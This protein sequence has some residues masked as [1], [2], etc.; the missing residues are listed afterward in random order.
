[1]KIS[2]IQNTHVLGTETRLSF[3]LIDEFRKKGIDVIVN[4]CDDE[5]DVILCMNGLSQFPTVK[6]ISNKYPNKKV[7]IYVWDVY[8]W[9][10]YASGYDDIKQVATEIWVPSSEVALRLNE[11]YNISKHKIKVIKSYVEF[12]D[13]DHNNSI[14]RKFVFHPVR[15]YSDPNY[16]FTER[17]CDELNIPCIRSN[18]SLNYEEYKETILNCSFLVTEYMEASTGGLTL[19]EGYKHGKNV[20][21]SDSIYQG[22]R[23]YFGHRAYYFKD[24]DYEDFKNK[25]KM[26]WELD[27]EIDL[28]DR[29]EFCKQFDKE[30]IVDE[31]LKNITRIKDE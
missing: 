16:G 12:F 21:I 28:K 3:N 23:D 7:I 2:Y 27:E 31:I 18:H 15:N 17:A 25:I 30:T 10:S 29:N 1:M 13:H 8:P 11:I 5:C 6:N 19:L 22:A 24:G 4:G 14:S 20:L 9:T 26:L